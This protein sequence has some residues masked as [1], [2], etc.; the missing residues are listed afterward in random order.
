MA[1][2]IPGRSGSSSSGRFHGPSTH[3]PSSFG[4][5]IGVR[6]SI[7]VSADILRQVPFPPGLLLFVWVGCRES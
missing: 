3:G 7:S 5:M 4:S 6:P 2:P 1:T